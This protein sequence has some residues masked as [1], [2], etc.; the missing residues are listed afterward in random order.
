MENAASL[1]FMYYNFA[2]TH[3][4]LKVTPAFAAGIT[5]HTWS[6][7]EIAAMAA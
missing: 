5:N 3:E 4:T 1:H 6:L 7:A 2:R